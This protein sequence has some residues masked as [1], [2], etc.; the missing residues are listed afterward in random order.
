MIMKKIDDE[1]AAKEALYE[2]E[3]AIDFEE[4]SDN[5]TGEGALMKKFYDKI[6]NIDI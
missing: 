2:H 1:I 5:E 6:S 4:D 3:K